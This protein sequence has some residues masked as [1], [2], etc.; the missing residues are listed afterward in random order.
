MNQHLTSRG[1]HHMEA[2]CFMTYACEKCQHRERIW[3]SR[4][5]VTPFSM[6]CP[7]CNDPAMTMT[8]VEWQNDYY[9]PNAK[10]EPGALFWRDGTSAEAAEMMRKR[11]ERAHGT[12][13][14]LKPLAA[15]ELIEAVRRGEGDF[16]KGWPKLDR[17]THG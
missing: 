6:T 5:G 9:E 8:H 12:A 3:N 16:Q 4:D 1:H 17:V 7:E 15:A 13:Y 14:E 11:I 10:L 2:F